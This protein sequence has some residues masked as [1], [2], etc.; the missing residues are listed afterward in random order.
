M[1]DQNVVQALQT[2]QESMLQE[3]GEPLARTLSL[4]RADVIDRLWE[5]AQQFRGT[6]TVENRRHTPA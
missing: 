4:S 6:R 1:K 5:L 3:S 2:K